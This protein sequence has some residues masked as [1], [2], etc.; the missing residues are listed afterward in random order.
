[1]RLFLK[2]RGS[3]LSAPF[4]TSHSLIINLAVADLLMGFYLIMLGI[5]GGVYSGRFCAYDISW[6]SSITCKIMGVLV[7]LSSE[8]SV[9]T[10]LLLASFR[11]FAVLKVRV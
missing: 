4:K 2:K 8:T 3:S 7:V 9:M 11:L 6:R 5:A 10:M 1:M